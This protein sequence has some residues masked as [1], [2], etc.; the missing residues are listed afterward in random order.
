MGTNLRIVAS[1]SPV[2]ELHEELRLFFGT[3]EEGGTLG[4]LGINRCFRR[5]EIKNIC[6]SAPAAMFVVDG[7]KELA[8]DN[9]VF[10][11]KAGEILFVPG[12][13]Q[14]HVTNMPGEAGQNFLAIAIIFDDQVLRQFRQMYGSRFEDWD[15][16]PKWH[17]KSRESVMVALVH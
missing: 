2:R 3:D 14:I 8:T 4:R 7:I 17:V 12:G 15:L 11:A 13:S 1:D 6:N 16:T 5:Q 9:N 10:Q